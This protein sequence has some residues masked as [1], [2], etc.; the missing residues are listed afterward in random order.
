M[1][2]FNAINAIRSREVMSKPCK[3]TWE[4]T[5]KNKAFAVITKGED[6]KFYIH[7]PNVKAVTAKSFM[8]AIS[9]ILNDYLEIVAVVLEESIKLYKISLNT[10]KMAYERSIKSHN[11]YVILHYTGLYALGTG[12]RQYEIHDIENLFLNEYPTTSYN[13]TLGDALTK[14]I[15]LVEKAIKNIENTLDEIIKSL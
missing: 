4:F 3:D 14:N 5:L 11:K 1:N 8:Q 13:S 12:N 9:L 15:K 10:L 2:K 7:R 6:N